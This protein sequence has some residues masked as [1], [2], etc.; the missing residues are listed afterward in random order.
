MATARTK[1]NAKARI[2]KPTT[3][4][5]PTPQASAQVA[6]SAGNEQAALPASICNLV[7]HAEVIM[8]GFSAI[9][10]HMALG[11][12]R[13]DDLAACVID[14]A[15]INAAKAADEA[16]LLRDYGAVILRRAAHLPE[17]YANI[18]S[19]AVHVIELVQRETLLAAQSSGQSP[20][21]A[22]ESAAS[23][24]AAPAEIPAN[25]AMGGDAEV[26]DA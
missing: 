26:Q 17:S 21:P 14:D 10:L 13:P 3:G 12:P 2:S 1:R 20:K 16:T 8:P 9:L 7:A 23:A 25:A 18:Q 11:L 4:L 22:P 15:V 6:A 19:I 5:K 24:S